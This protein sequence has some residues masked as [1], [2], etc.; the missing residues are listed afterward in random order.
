MIVSF[1]TLAEQ[2]EYMRVDICGLGGNIGFVYQPHVS[3]HCSGVST[4]DAHNSITLHAFGFFA[5]HMPQKIVPNW[6][7]TFILLEIVNLSPYHWILITC[8]VKIIT[9][10]IVIIHSHRC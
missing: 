5:I 8:K 7:N 10:A 6:I 9:S 2:S 3:P 4:F 1:S